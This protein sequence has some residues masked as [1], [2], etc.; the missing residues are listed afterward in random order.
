[1]DQEI[2]RLSAAFRLVVVPSRL[3]EMVDTRNHPSLNVDW[4][5]A[6]AYQSVPKIGNFLIRALISYLLS[7]R[8]SGGGRHMIR[9]FWFLIQNFRSAVV[10]CVAQEWTKESL[11]QSLQIDLFYTWWFTTESLAIA[12]VAKNFKIPTI[13][14][15]HGIDIYEKMYPD[16]SYV[17]RDEF[18]DRLEAI[19]PDSE[20]GTRYLK[21][22]FPAIAHRVRTQYLGIACSATPKP[23]VAIS[24]S[25]LRIVSCSNHHPVK[26]IE[27]LLSVARELRRR[28]FAYSW[29]HIGTGGYSPLELVNRILQFRLDLQTFRFIEH[30]GRAWLLDFYAESAFDLFVNLSST[31]GL[32]VAVMEAVASGLPILGTNVG[33][34]PEI[35]LEEVNGFLVEA[36]EH[37]FGIADKVMEIAQDRHLLQSMGLASRGVFETRFEADNN[38][39]QFAQ[40]LGDLLDQASGKKNLPPTISKSV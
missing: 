28:G 24:N 40:L 11:K 4:T 39:D 38:Y 10:F 7:S 13:T 9:R 2:E 31:E 21:E 34:L 25:P 20:S 6:E 15:A 36:S 26:R 8:K 37:E 1:M 16:F 14:R 29:T 19:L 23:R 17:F 12:D 27:L 18:I 33:G 32:P 30:Q 22:Q 3:G 35:A 5:L